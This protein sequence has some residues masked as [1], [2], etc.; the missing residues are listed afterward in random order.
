MQLD[1]LVEASNSVIVV[2][3]DMRVV[4]ASDWVLVACSRNPDSKDCRPEHAFD[5]AFTVHYTAGVTRLPRATPTVG[6][7]SARR[8]TTR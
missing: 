4:A 7:R 2:E 6:E 5:V 3:H 1:R 8:T